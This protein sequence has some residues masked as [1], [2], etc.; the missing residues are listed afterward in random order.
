[1]APLLP[2]ASAER[3]EWTG[4]SHFWNSPRAHPGQVALGCQLGTQPGREAGGFPH[5]RGSRALRMS[6]QKAWPD[7]QAFVWPCL[8]R[9][10]HVALV[11]MRVCKASPRSRGRNY[12]PSLITMEVTIPKFLPVSEAIDDCSDGYTH[13]A[14]FFVSFR[15]V[16]LV[17]Y[18]HEVSV[19]G[20]SVDLFCPLIF[21]NYISCIFPHTSLSF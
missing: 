13:C 8:G 7:V 16:N 1:M 3:L 15:K 4:R 20:L 12:S 17:W 21:G 10:C 9:P 6:V 18:V 14:G 5:I 19:S 2:G 11:T